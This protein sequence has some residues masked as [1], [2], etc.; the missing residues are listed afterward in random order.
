MKRFLII[1]L[2]IL[3]V[4]AG[5][6]ADG[7]FMP[8]WITEDWFAQAGLYSS[9]W[10]NMAGVPTA[11]TLMAGTDFTLFKHLELTGLVK[12]YQNPDAVNLFNPFETAFVLNADVVIVDGV[13]LGLSQEWD[14]YPGQV[15]DQATYTEFYVK[16]SG[17]VF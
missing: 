7:I 9:T 13:R 6:W 15:I 16:V 1:A 3:A 12:E 11:V 4:V 17:K 8:G 5:T 14:L 10:A 2:L